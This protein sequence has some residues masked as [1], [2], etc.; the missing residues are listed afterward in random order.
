MITEE[1]MQGLRDYCGQTSRH[2]AE[3]DGEIVVFHSRPGEEQADLGVVEE[4][5]RVMKKLPV[6][7]DKAPVG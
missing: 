1:M 5:A 6:N 3:I 4:L 7:F 2:E